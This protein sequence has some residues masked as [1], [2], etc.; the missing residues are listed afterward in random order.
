MNGARIVSCLTLAIMKDG[1]EVTTIEGLAEGSALH[2]LQ[3]AFIEH[4]AFQCGYCTPGQICSALGLMHEGRGR[5][6]DEIRELMSGN[7]CRCGAYPNILA[8]IQEAMEAAGAD[9]LGHG[10]RRLGGE[11]GA[12]RSQSRAHR[13]RQA[14]RQQL[15]TGTYTIM[16]QIAAETLGLPLGDVT[17]RLG[18]STLA[19]APIEGGSWT[20]SSVGSAVKAACDKVCKRLFDLARRRCPPSPPPALKT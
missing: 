18:D 19:T 7:L 5:T 16:T 17:F 9:R 15:G 11:P 8:A 20:A 6:A 3:A 4:D 14:H 13:R 2:P 10:H 12:G 1:A